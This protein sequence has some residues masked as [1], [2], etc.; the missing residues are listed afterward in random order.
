MKELIYMQGVV[1]ISSSI[2]T[3]AMLWTCSIGPLNIPLYESCSCVKTANLT[4]FRQKLTDFNKWTIIFFLLKS[5]IT[6]IHLEVWE[7]K[8]WKSRMRMD[9]GVISHPMPLSVSTVHAKVGW[10]NVQQRFKR[11]PCWWGLGKIWRIRFKQL[12]NNN[13]FCSSGVKIDPRNP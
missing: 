2:A 7:H 1:K 12:K 4:T 11:P 10:A 9:F 8:F 5:C 3:V 13:V 6:F